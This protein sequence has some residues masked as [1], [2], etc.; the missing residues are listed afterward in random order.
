MAADSVDKAFE[1]L[2]VLN[3]CLK[4]IHWFGPG[5]SGREMRKDGDRCISLNHWSLVDYSKCTIAAVHSACRARRTDAIISLKP[6]VNLNDCDE[7]GWTVLHTAMLHSDAAVR[8]LFG[9]GI[10]DKKTSDGV[11]ASSLNPERWERATGQKVI[12]NDYWTVPSTMQECANMLVLSA[13]SSSKFC[14]RLRKAVAIWGTTVLTII[15]PA[16]GIERRSVFHVCCS[17]TYCATRVCIELGVS[18]NQTDRWNLTPLRHA[19]NGRKITCMLLLLQHGAVVDNADNKGWTPLHTAGAL[20]NRECAHLL[21]QHGASLNARTNGGQTPAD[22]ARHRG[23]DSFADAL[24][25]LCVVEQATGTT[26]QEGE[27]DVEA[28]SAKRQRRV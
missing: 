11:Y 9:F 28:P 15:C 7:M 16:K 18:V 3:L 23:Y 1:D 4:R 22:L 27:E 26:H 8:T 17:S 6:H 21:L 12:N 20:G 5:V 13:S 19:C 14:N 10:A 24:D 2:L 25:Y